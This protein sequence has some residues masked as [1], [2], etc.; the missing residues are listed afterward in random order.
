MLTDNYIHLVQKDRD[1][2]LSGKP[3]YSVGYKIE[4][5]EGGKPD[6]IFAT[7]EWTGKRLKVENCRYG[8]YPIYYFTKPGEICVS[9][10]IPR[11]VQEG[12][13][14]ELDEPALAVFLRLGYFLGEDTPF[15]AIRTLPPDTTF[16]WQEDQLKIAGKLPEVKP[17]NL[18][19]DEAIDAYIETFR[20]AIHRRLPK[21]EFAVPLSG[22]RDSRHI[23]LELSAAGYRPKFCVTSHHFPPRNNDDVKIA[24]LLTKILGIEHIILP[25]NQSRVQSELRKN[26]MT[27]FGAIKHGWA[28]P[29]VDYVDNR[30]TEIYDGIAGGVL[31][32]SFSLF[33]PELVNLYETGNLVEVAE[34]LLSLNPGLEHLLTSGSRHKF[35]KE[36]AISRLVSELEKHQN[37]PNP[38][39]SYLF[40]N[41]T[42]RTIATYSF[43]MFSEQLN[44]YAPYLDHEVYNLLTSLPASY[45]F[46]GTFHAET[47]CRAFPEFKDIPF[48][49]QWQ[50]EYTKDCY[51]EY[52]RELINYAVYLGSSELISLSFLLPRLVQGY[53]NGQRLTIE[54]FEPRKAIYLLQLED[55]LKN[56]TGQTQTPR[57]LAADKGA[58]SNEKLEKTIDKVAAEFKSELHILENNIDSLQ[59]LYI[60]QK[61]TC[62]QTIETLIPEGET[63]ILVDGEQ[64]AVDVI[65][66]RQKLPFLEQDGQ[67]WGAPPD[68][69]T[70]ISELARLR[71]AGANFIVFI[72]ETFWCLDYYLEFSKYLR[73]QF[74]CLLE[75]EFLTIF[76]LRDKPE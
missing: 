14:T 21:G 75:N 71:Q 3:T 9:T 59:P 37:Q 20:Q 15:K 50:L 22:G 30:V 31:T 44:V 58:V 29:V 60:Q 35:N 72:W 40:W 73:S 69:E 4:R 68:D 74:Q 16:E 63:F 48:E 1:I 25:Q 61:L 13:T 7:W 57:F 6:G 5:P 70:A 32:P 55:F 53:R 66:H 36:S 33:N 65:P 2:F 28:L 17:Q 24:G 45:S 41:L 62:L 11:L 51:R 64:L 27:S 19:R 43:S 47:I 8:L 46:G 67:Y 42:R 34:P 76:D 12:A 49:N 18:S 39:V 56:Q 38:A 26:I 52:A 54:W 23:L 10:S